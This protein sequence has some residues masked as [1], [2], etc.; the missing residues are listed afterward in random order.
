MI[1]RGFWLLAGAAG[2]IIA[3]QTVARA[4]PDGYTLLLYSGF[5]WVLP[6]MKSVPYDPVRDFLPVTWA[7]AAPSR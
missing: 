2:G 7:A 4:Q 3:A 6:L 5:I 1:R